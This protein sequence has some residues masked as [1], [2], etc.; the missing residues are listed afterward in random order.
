MAKKRYIVKLRR[1]KKE[2]DANGVVMRDDWAKYTAESPKEATPQ[3]AEL[4]LEYDNGV[5]RL[6]IGNGRDP[7]SALPY[8]GMKNCIG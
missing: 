7:F 8:M 5:P 3:D 2:T 6:K 4:V 1:G